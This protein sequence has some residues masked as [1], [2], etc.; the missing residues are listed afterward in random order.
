MLFLALLLAL[1]NLRLTMADTLV[2][3]YLVTTSSPAFF[4]NTR[5]LPDVNATSLFD[6]YMFH[7][8]AYYLRLI[9]PGYGSLP[10]FSLVDGFLTTNVTGPHG[11]GKYQYWSHSV[12]EHV[13]FWFNDQLVTGGR[14][15]T[16]E[17]GFLLG[18]EGDVEG[19]R[20]CPGDLQQEVLVWKGNDTGCVQR[21]VQAVKQAP[22]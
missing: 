1:L 13:P 22:Y 3:F 20:V 15:L 17:K 6:P 11:Q 10:C 14:T 4:S 12:S 8:T 21:Y 18:V 5:A 16:L 9:G 19:W 7:N 2:D